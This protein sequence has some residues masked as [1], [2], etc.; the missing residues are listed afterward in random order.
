MI[1]F[2][3]GEGG[4]G[5]TERGTPWRDEGYFANPKTS[6]WNSTRHNEAI[7]PSGSHVVPEEMSFGVVGFVSAY[8]PEHRKQ[9]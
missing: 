7:P 6:E 5:P 1:S 8:E 2:G 3:V 4:G 9:D